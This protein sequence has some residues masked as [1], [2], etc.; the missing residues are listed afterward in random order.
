MSTTKDVEV[1]FIHRL[2]K[3]FTFNGEYASV[4]LSKGKVLYTSFMAQKLRVYKYE[5]FQGICVDIPIEL[6]EIVMVTKT[7]EHTV[8][9]TEVEEI[10][11]YS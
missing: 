7:T 2:A 10:V 4:T 1:K 5:L 9:V 3:E 6:V 8:K 11:N